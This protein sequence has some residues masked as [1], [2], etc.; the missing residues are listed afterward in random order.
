[1]SQQ[2]RILAGVF[3]IGNNGGVGFQFL[4]GLH[5]AG[6]TAAVVGV[7]RDDGL[8]REVILV[9][10]RVDRHR[11]IAPPVGITDEDGIVVVK[12]VDVVS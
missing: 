12:V 3:C 2:S 7:E 9:K 8:A 1:M 6:Q 10:E 4:N 5:R 11:Q